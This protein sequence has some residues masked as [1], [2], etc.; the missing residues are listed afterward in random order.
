[1]SFYRVSQI[2]TTNENPVTKLT[3]VVNRPNP[4]TPHPS[5]LKKTCRFPFKFSGK[6]DV[7]MSAVE[8]MEKLNSSA[9]I[10]K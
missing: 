1:M 10:D 9:L 6:F 4:L 7:V 2:I 5:P 3:E 8:I